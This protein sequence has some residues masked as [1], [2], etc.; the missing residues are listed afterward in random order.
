VED[1]AATAELIL[2][3]LDELKVV[4]DSVIANCLYLGICTDT[5]AF[6]HKNVTA[7]TFKASARLIEYGADNNLINYEMFEKQSKERAKLF[8]MTMDKMRFYLDD[9]LAIITV[10]QENIKKC[11]VSSDVTEGFINFPLSID[12]I[13][14]ALCLLEMNKYLYKVSL[15][16][17]GKAN[18]NAIAAIYGGGGHILASGCMIGGALEEVIDKL[19]YSVSQFI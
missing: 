18:V 2:L 11:N 12:K 10:S 15:R 14:V 19:I 3:L 16:S 1:K 5:G 4:P 17:K 9:K 6:A 8:S 13:E 7:D